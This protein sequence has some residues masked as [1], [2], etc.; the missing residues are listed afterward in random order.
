MQ[1]FAVIYLMSGDRKRKVKRARIVPNKR[2][3]KGQIVFSVQRVSDS[4]FFSVREYFDTS[5]L[6]E[7]LKLDT[8]ESAVDKAHHLGYE[9]VPSE[10]EK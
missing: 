8:H 2:K 7:A 6:D 9:V 3:E 10:E 5:S 4:M 1:G